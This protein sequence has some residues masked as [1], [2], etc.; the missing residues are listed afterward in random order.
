MNGIKYLLDTNIIIGMYQHSP[1]VIDLMQAKRVHI[2]Q[3]AYSAITRMELL[4]FPGIT[5]TEETAIHAL[6]NRMARLSIT[7]DVEEQAIRFRRRHKTKLP[8]SIIGATASFHDL[9]LLTMDKQL[10]AKL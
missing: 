4:S 7:E 1:A 2:G 3:C 5:P 6:L 9:E 8:D 10:Q